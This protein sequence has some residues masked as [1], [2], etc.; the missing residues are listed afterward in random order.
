MSVEPLV[1]A[2]WLN[3]HLSD[4]NVRPVDVRWYLTEPGRGKAEY[5]EAHI[6]GAPFMDMEV[7]LSAPRGEGPGRHPMPTPERFAAAAGRAGIG[8]DTHVIAYDASG[9]AAAAR[10]WWLLRYFG[11]DRVSL[12]DGGWPAW[13]AGGRPGRP[14]AVEQRDA[15]VAEVAQQPPQPRRVGAR[16]RV[17][18]DHVRVGADPGPPV[19]VEQIERDLIQAALDRSGGNISETARSLG[20]T[21]RG[22][23]LKLRRL[24]FESRPELDVQ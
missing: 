20:L 23:Y 15:L 19:A 14:A 16:A 8:S 9:G 2:A 10:L 12:L 4:P 17:V 24:G 21:R 6:A 18:G 5:A 3:D 22:L 11:H 7:D 1:T 13:Q